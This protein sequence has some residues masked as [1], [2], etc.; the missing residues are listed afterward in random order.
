MQSPY[1][2]NR[3]TPSTDALTKA[4]IMQAESVNVK[5]NQLID[6][7]DEE[8]YDAFV[9]EIMV[10]HSQWTDRNNPSYNPQYYPQYFKYRNLAIITL[11]EKYNKES[12]ELSKKF[13]PLTSLKS[14]MGLISALKKQSI[15]SSEIIE[16]CK[17]CTNT[18]NKADASN[19]EKIHSINNLR[20]GLSDYCSTNNLNQNIADPLYKQ[21]HQLDHYLTN[22][23][24]LNRQY[25]SAREE[26]TEAT[27]IIEEYRT[28]RSEIEQENDVKRPVDGQKNGRKSEDIVFEYLVNQN[29]ATKM[30]ATDDADSIVFLRM[31]YIKDGEHTATAGTKYEFDI[32]K[33]QLSPDDEQNI[34]RIIEICEVKSGYNSITN[35]YIKFQAGYAKLMDLK[36]LHVKTGQTFK[37]YTIDPTAFEE[38]TIRY[39]IPSSK[40]IMYP[41]LSRV[42]IECLLLNPEI[43]SIFSNMTITN[44]EKHEQLMQST[45]F[46]A[47]FLEII[48]RNRKLVDMI[49]VIRTDTP[50]SSACTPNS[51]EEKTIAEPPCSNQGRYGLFNSI[52]AVPEQEVLLPHVCRKQP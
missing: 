44:E 19:E 45:S 31:A 37:E 30:S 38:T 34:I 43:M 9:S 7:L 32:I 24:T 8:N 21:L 26:I 22:L 33:M 23:I 29:S 41:L 10:L 47:R 42:S 18:L 40:P 17:R 3:L 39:Y 14:S 1:E 36:V 2:N 4:S 51:E 49:T 6:L 5:E 12:E 50:S 13:N 15:D 16:M 48:D 20:A 11:Y 46:I 25:Q 52:T 35:D 27:S 28:L